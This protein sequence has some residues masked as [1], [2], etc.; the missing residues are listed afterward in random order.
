MD[1]AAAC[2]ICGSVCARAGPVVHNEPTRVAGVPIDL[3]GLDQVMMRCPACALMFK[4]PFV[5]EA[6]LV[7][8]YESAPGDQWQDDPDPVARRFDDIERVV[9]AHA[10][11]HRL[12]DIGCSNGALL[13]FMGSSWSRC[14][15][16]PGIE[17]ARLA[18][19]RG[20]EILGSMIDDLGDAERFD[21]MLAI[22]VLEHLTDPGAFVARVRRA[23]A[24]GGVF[25]ALTGDTDTP[26]WRWHGTRY[27]YAAL[28]EHQVFFSRATIERLARDHAMTLAHYERTSHARF[29]ASRRVRDAVRGSLWGLAGRL[30]L[31]GRGPAPGWLPARD[32]MLVALVADD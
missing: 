29:S 20:V 30:R 28:P 25:V 27:W 8:C 18:R 31:G 14:G 7:R 1:D 23:L 22:D 6:Q 21:G 3:S 12:L 2:P 5:P 10:T 9:R 17:A 15:I 16:E 13:A 11:G 24:P 4:H 26:S 32:H 19:D